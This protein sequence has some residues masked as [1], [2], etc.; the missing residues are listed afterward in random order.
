MH[1]TPDTPPD[2]LH[3]VLEAVTAN[4]LEWRRQHSGQ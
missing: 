2:K 4:Q 1:I 3:T